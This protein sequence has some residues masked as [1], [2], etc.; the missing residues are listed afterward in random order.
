MAEQSPLVIPVFDLVLCLSQAVDLV[1]PLVADH[2][3]RTA[4]IAYG[5]GM[6][7]R[8]PESELHD[9][10]IAAALHDAGGL[11]CKDRLCALD[12]EFQDPYGHSVM[13]YLFLNSFSPFRTPADIVRFH[14]VPW[15]NGT[16]ATFDGIPIPR[17]S[18]ILQLA[19]RVAVLL[20]TNLDVL[21]QVDGIL[22]KVRAQSGERF[23]PEQVKALEALAK[24]ES[25]WLDAIYLQ[26]I[27]ILG[28]RLKWEQM[29][30]TEDDFLG[31]TNLFRR[32][33]DFRS[34]FTASH[35]AGVAATAEILAR[36][37]GFSDADCRMIHLAGL[38]HDLGKLAVPVEILEKPGRLT[39]QEFAV[40]RRHTY[41]TF[42]LLEPLKVLDLIRVWGAFH[43]E[44]MDGNGYPFHLEE[45]ELPLG[46]RIVSVADVFNALTED[47]PYRKGIPGTDA[48]KILADAVSKHRLDH[49]VVATLHDHLNEVNDARRSAQFLAFKEYRH[50][51]ETAEMLTHRT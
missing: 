13:G 33:V 6:Q 48:F 44:R 46:S 10:I 5:L 22:E 39:R 45:N 41:Y 9:L 15:M 30:I 40:I 12:F 1:N 24:K 49:Q 32:I 28:R 26:H 14:H 47:R 19:D 29:Q 8:L 11:T 25:F 17:A 16:G 34:Q 2:Q 51:V 38:L 42:H 37:C 4:Q 3:K 36:R 50:F 35:S 21:D 20:N 31:L 18:H 7:M 43:H 23:V 27:N